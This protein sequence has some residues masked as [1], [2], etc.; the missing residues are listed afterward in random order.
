MQKTFIGV[1]LVILAV[2][3]F[4]LDNSKI[5]VINFWVWKL[6][7]NLSLVLI[8]S[9]FFGALSS[10]LFSLPYRAKKNREIKKRDKIIKTL[11]EKIQQFDIGL[12]KPINGI[13]D[14]PAKKTE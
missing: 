11:E 3:L 14:E 6:E 1:L 7:S 12:S 10:F 9:V 8:V 2:V 5:I 4:S 13:N